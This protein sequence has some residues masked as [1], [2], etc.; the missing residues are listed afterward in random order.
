MTKYGPEGATG[1][2]LLSATMLGG[3]KELG[4][5]R[6]GAENRT[7]ARRRRK[8]FGGL[9]LKEKRIEQVLQWAAQTLG[10]PM[11]K[12]EREMLSQ[13]AEDTDRIRRQQT[14]L[15]HRVSRLIK[16]DPA[17]EDVRRRGEEGGESTAAV[18]RVK[19]G[20]FRDD[21]AP[22]ALWNGFG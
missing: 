12:E 6:K 13:L 17:F 2:N 5:P 9:F 8:Q 18:F 1:W 4:G 15:T 11:M 19:V 7:K 10:Q 20:D 14:E 3:L 16:E 22:K 21:K